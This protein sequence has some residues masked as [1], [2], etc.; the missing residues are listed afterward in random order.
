MFIDLPR[1]V[2][3]E[4]DDLVDFVL[5]EA[6]FQTSKNGD[7]RRLALANNF[8]LRTSDG[9]TLEIGFNPRTQCTPTEGFKAD[10]LGSFRISGFV[11]PP[12]AGKAFLILTEIII[13]KRFPPPT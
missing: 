3:F 9:V 7:P 5:E 8:R 12:Q 4:G 6:V 10:F 13:I 11:G 2:G 1:G